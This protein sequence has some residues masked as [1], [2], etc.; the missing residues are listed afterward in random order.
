[1]SFNPYYYENIVVKNPDLSINDISGD[2][3]P[4]KIYDI[5]GVPFE[6]PPLLTDFDISYITF[7]PNSGSVLAMNLNMRDISNVNELYI[8]GIQVKNVKINFFRDVSFTNLQ[9]LDFNKNPLNFNLYTTDDT[10]YYQV[11]NNISYINTKTSDLSSNTVIINFTNS[12]QLPMFLNFERYTTNNIFFIGAEQIQPT[13][14]IKEKI[15]E[16]FNWIQAPWKDISINDTDI[17]DGS[18]LDI[19]G[20]NYKLYNTKNVQGRKIF[21][22]TPI[23]IS[24]LGY[25]YFTMNFY[26]QGYT[27]SDNVTNDISIVDI[28]TALIKINDDLSLNAHLSKNIYL[29]I[30]SN[31]F[32]YLDITSDNIDLSTNSNSESAI[33]LPINTDVSFNFLFNQYNNINTQIS[34]NN[35]DIS[36]NYIDFSTINN[37]SDKLPIKDESYNNIAYTSSDI[38]ASYF[39]ITTDMPIIR[40]L[41]ESILYQS[42]YGRAFDL[43]SS[44][45]HKI[46]S[47]N[48]NVLNI[49]INSNYSNKL[50]D[51]S[52]VYVNNLD[53]SNVY[54]NGTNTTTSMQKSIFKNCDISNGKIVTSNIDVSDISGSRIYILKSLNIDSAS[55]INN[56]SDFSYVHLITYN[57]SDLINLDACANMLSFGI[58]SEILM[59]VNL[60]ISGTLTVS[61][62]P[63][64]LEGDGFLSRIITN[65]RASINTADINSIYITSDDRYK[66]NEMDISNAINIINQIKPK[67]YIK[68]DKL[69]APSHNFS[70]LP[71]DAIMDAGFIAQELTTIPDLSYVVNY[72][73]NINSV[74][75]SAIQP[76]LVKSLQ[77]L[78]SIINQQTITISNLQQDIELLESNS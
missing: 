44:I 37:I 76:Y 46:D 20:L 30:N 27:D 38:S 41:S 56:I 52:K 40:Y 18:G 23:Q 77:E 64:A 35:S 47:S 66:H 59:P 62:T 69:Y 57:N 39:I 58:S 61:D 75:Y 3:L 31:L 28:S 8:D 72:N 4:L 29:N 6:K 42:K 65:Y 60:D 1:M 5:S 49:N 50:F 71:N 14:I 12:V 36:A 16:N 13:S 45:V 25:P 63:D 9:F 26:Y 43:D 68:T 48:V 73:N 33:K 15:E 74:N 22:N 78:Y 54:F 51:S 70:T 55:F 24:N 11:A 7:V 21:T 32:S 67:K 19:S 10:N 2:Y 34:Y 17:T 53:V